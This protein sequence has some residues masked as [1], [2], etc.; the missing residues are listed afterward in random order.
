M[1]QGNHALWRRMLSAANAVILAALTLGLAACKVTEPSGETPFDKTP[2]G[3]TP[4][5]L[6]AVYA[7]YMSY[8][9]DDVRYVE[10]IKAHMH[11]GGAVKTGILSAIPTAFL[12][13]QQD[14]LY[15]QLTY[16]A[17]SF[18]LRVAASALSGKND[19][20]V[21]FAHGMGISKITLEEGFKDIRRFRDEHPSEFIEISLSWE[22][23]SRVALSVADVAYIHRQTDTYL[24]PS[25]YAFP[26]GT[27]LGTITMKEMRDSGK[28]FMIGSEW[29]DPVYNSGH[30]PMRGTSGG[31]DFP[32]LED[33][34]A[35]Y[36]YLRGLVS[37]PNPGRCLW[38]GFGR[39]T[40]E[41]VS[42]KLTPLQYM[43][44]DRADFEDFMRYLEDNPVFLNNLAGF[45]FD[46]FTY[47][48]VQ[49][50]RTLL[51]N[52]LKGIIKPELKAKYVRK[53]AGSFGYEIPSA[54][55]IVSE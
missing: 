34:H 17:R 37:A 14:S 23:R 43:L 18:D 55:G 13:C 50:G 29:C 40:G 30:S 41:N 36:S 5:A 6:L 12:D 27:D 16:G 53:I 33:G 49:P 21:Y 3:K 24:E 44:Q 20:A 35:M 52:A 25:K 32:K 1:K 10:V 19:G 45:T 51:L 8:V 4:E 31:S 54:Y 38:P 26:R 48:Y 46:R 15:T 28:N 42:P 9:R 2:P 22:Y 11:D 47:D 39:S 7:N